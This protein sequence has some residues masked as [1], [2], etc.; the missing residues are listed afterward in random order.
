[1]QRI[2]PLLP[3]L[4]AAYFLLHLFAFCCAR[5][6]A[7]DGWQWQNPLPQGNSLELVQFVD[8]QNGWMMTRG[9]TLMR[10]RDG[11]RSWEIL[12]IDIFL[13][14]VQFLNPRLGWAVGREEFA[15]FNR[16]LYHTTDGGKSW[17]RQLQGPPIRLAVFFLDSLQG[18]IPDCHRIYHTIDG[19]KTWTVQAD[20]SWATTCLSD[21]MFKDALH[22]WGFGDGWGIR[23]E[24]GGKTWARDSNANSG[25]KIA[26]ADSTHG[27]LASFRRLRRTTDGGRTWTILT[28]VPAFSSDEYFEDLIA[29]N[30]RR[31]LFCT[32]Q[33]LYASNDSGFHWEK[34]TEQS[35]GKMAFL[36]SSNA[37]AVNYGPAQYR[38]NDGGRTWQKLLKE[39][40]PDRIIFFRDVDFVNAQVGWALAHAA[41]PQ[42]RY[43]L[44]TIDG[45]LNWFELPDAPNRRLRALQFLGL[46]LGWAVGDDGKVY[47]TPNGGTT[48]LDRSINTSDDMNAVYF[49][50]AFQGWAAGGGFATDAGSV[51]KTLDGGQTWVEFSPPDIKRIWGAAFVDTLNAWVV[52]G[53]SSAGDAG[54]IWRTSDGGLSW[55]RQL[56][57]NPYLDFTSIAFAD[58]NTGWAAGFDHQKGGS[59]YTTTDGGRNW[60][61]QTLL[62]FAPLDIAVFNRQNVLIAGF[63]GNIIATTDGGQTWVSQRSPTSNIL[64]AVD[65]VDE[66][67]GWIV[68]SR[69]TILHT[70]SGGTIA[71]AEKPRPQI[72]PKSFRLL[73]SHPNPFTSSTQ[74]SFE[75][76]R[77]AAAVQLTLYD[78]LGR[79]MRTL[80]S[81]ALPAGQHRAAWDGRDDLGRPSASGVYLY[82]LQVNQEWQIGK[83]LLTR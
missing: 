60:H 34:Y 48:W 72:P 67:N 17:H 21:V 55:E 79:K 25:R 57:N 26:F 71:V 74:I 33:G 54:S 5:A 44:K 35:L 29:F 56:P 59:I 19:G 73:W 62:H 51:W 41:P 15:D 36:D 20:S 75:L 42:T 2:L 82:R 3:P 40:V 68:G 52:T 8:Q 43:L 23:T 7:Q 76:Y 14:Q 47:Y 49:F 6:L 16:N 65:F 63:S 11:G 83:V 61:L 66:K 81:T 24:D 1:M 28:S 22:G 12:Y 31:V 38:T 58:T 10:T 18:W 69:S 32:S 64:E 30:R 53:G 45:G 13:D 80:V 9:P 46:E 4:R 70:K 27:W 78:V 50:N 39:I 77:H 37:W